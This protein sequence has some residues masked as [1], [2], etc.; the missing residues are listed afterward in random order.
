M[1]LSRLRPLFGLLAITAILG[2][3]ASAATD[4]P[5][6]SVRIV[7]GFAP[8]GTTDLL[9]R[10]VADQLRVI[11]NTSVVVEN[12]SGRGWHHR[13]HDGSPGTGRRLHAA[14]EHQCDCHNASPEGPTL[15]SDRRLRADH[16]R[17]A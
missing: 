2:A 1:T 5:N 8:G 12:R 17:R 7:V 3:P 4:F 11:W 6:R 13:H 16:H 15:R 14:D 10:I 9:A